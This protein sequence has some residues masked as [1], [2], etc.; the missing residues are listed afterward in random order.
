MLVSGRVLGEISGHFTS[1]AHPFCQNQAKERGELV[2]W[3]FFL[4]GDF[5]GGKKMMWGGGS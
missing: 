5:L 3:M 4:R 2:G 1:S